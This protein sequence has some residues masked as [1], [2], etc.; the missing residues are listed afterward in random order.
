MIP[1]LRFLIAALHDL[2]RMAVLG[3]VRGYQLFI[4][5]LIGPRCRFR[6]TCSQYA[7]L[8]VERYGPWIGGYKAIR[9]LLR[10]H[11]WSKGGWDP[12]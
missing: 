10:C 3:I 6:P 1:L 9:R 12:P 8:A 7:L 11:P 4:S 2:A 5:P